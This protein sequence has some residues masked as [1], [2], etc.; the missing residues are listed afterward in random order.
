M[1]FLTCSKS[2]NPF[3]LILLPLP[4]PFPP[5]AALNFPLFVLFTRHHAHGLA[6]LPSRTTFAQR[7]H[8]NYALQMGSKEGKKE[9]GTKATRTHRRSVFCSHPHRHHAQS[10]PSCPISYRLT[11]RVQYT[12]CV[13]LLTE[14][15][16]DHPVVVGVC[17]EQPLWNSWERVCCMPPLHLAWP[18]P[19]RIVIA[20]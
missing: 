1:N 14:P 15:R 4:S 5:R 8:S 6:R 20:R 17:F 7:T 2:L 13:P 19:T 3:P 10:S 18:S 12:Q 11:M 9:K 16:E